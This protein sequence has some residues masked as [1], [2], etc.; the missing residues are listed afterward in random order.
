M[1]MKKSNPFTIGFLLALALILL[2]LF[3][4]LG[5][6]LERGV[7]LSGATTQMEGVKTGLTNNMWTKATQFGNWQGCT[8]RVQK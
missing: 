3:I 4:D 5:M 1:A 6:A 8:P 7:G 2:A